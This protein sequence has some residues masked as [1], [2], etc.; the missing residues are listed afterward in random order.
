MVEHDDKPVAAPGPPPGSGAPPEP[1]GGPPPGAEGGPPPGAEGGPPPGPPPWAVPGPGRSSIRRA[2]VQLAVPMAL[3]EVVGLLV[4]VG[5]VALL[6]RMGADALYVRALYLPVASLFLA[7]FIAFD[8][9]N[10]VTAAINR[11]RGRPGNVAPTALSFARLWVVFASVLIITLVL[12]APLLADAL[13]VPPESRGHFV[14]F[15]RWMALAELS[16]VGVVLCASSLRGFGHARHGAV[17]MLT[18]AGLQF[19][20]VALLGFGAGMG[21]LSVPVSIAISSVVGLGIGLVLL[22]RTGLWQPGQRLPWQPESIRHLRQVGV[23]VAAT[24][25][26]LFGSNFVL[27]RV[28]GVFDSTVVSAFS[29]ASSLQILLLMPGIVL[30]SATA[31]VL[32]QQ[33]GAGKPGWL[34]TTLR[35]GLEV[36]IGVYVVLGVLAWLASEPLG[37]LMTD[38]PAVSHQAALYL[39]T[40]GL[41]YILQGPVLAC[42]NILEQL[43]AGLVAVTLN[44]LYYAVVVVASALVVSAMHDPVAFYRTVA[45]SNLAGI[46]VVVT[47]VIVVRRVSRAP[48]PAPAFGMGGPA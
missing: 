27:L 45:L 30:G 13:L 12:T 19:G 7:L 47:A 24:Q 35:T 40:V 18:G 16:Y 6:G 43:G 41:T 23:P 20:G 46:S 26:I 25:I 39:S 44:F 10:Q 15:V 4:V 42:L 3:A 5:V 11:G 37:K 17:V 28:L 29:S 21:A 14:T 8:I 48:A 34:P 38:V 1:A 33:R 32:N 36:A 2:L 22:R 31:I 9:S